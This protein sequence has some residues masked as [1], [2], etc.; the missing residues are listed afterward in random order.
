MKVYT[1]LVEE[2]NEFDE[3]EPSV[4]NCFLDVEAAKI[5]AK[6]FLC[7]NF[8]NDEDDDPIYKLEI[9]WEEMMDPEGKEVIVGSIDEA[10]LDE[11]KLNPY[12]HWPS[13]KIQGFD[14]K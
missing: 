13:F 11:L 8:N 9:T 14:L 5:A 1:L 12:A 2:I 3:V 4:Y 7:M 10:D 6:N